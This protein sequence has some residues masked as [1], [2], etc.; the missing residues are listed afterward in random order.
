[1]SKKEDQKF[2]LLE[3]LRKAT[4]TGKTIVENAISQSTSGD[5]SISETSV[6][7]SELKRLGKLLKKAE[8]A[9]TIGDLRKLLNEE[10]IPLELVIMDQFWGDF[11]KLIYELSMDER[12]R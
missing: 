12:E 8:K 1:M 5:V 7:A 10:T 6:K 11:Q 3:E 9:T 4:Q 2:D